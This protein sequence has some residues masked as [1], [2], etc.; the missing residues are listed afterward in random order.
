MTEGKG[1]AGDLAAAEAPLT[2]LRHRAERAAAEPNIV[3]AGALISAYAAAV[4][5]HI[6]SSAPGPEHPDADLS[7]PL[8]SLLTVIGA[9][10]AASDDPAIMIVDE[11]DPLGL[12]VLSWARAPLA[13]IAPWQ[14]AEAAGRTLVLARRVTSLSP[15]PTP[16]AVDL[17]VAC[18]LG[19]G[20]MRCVVSRGDQTWVWSVSTASA[21]LWTAVASADLEHVRRVVAES[22]DGASPHAAAQLAAWG[23][24]CRRGRAPAVD[25]GAI[26]ADARDDAPAGPLDADTA[27]SDIATAHR[28]AASLGHNAAQLDQLGALYAGALATLQRQAEHDIVEDQLLLSRRRSVVSNDVANSELALDAAFAAAA[29]RRSAMTFLGDHCEALIRG[30]CL[31]GIAAR[32]LRT[33]EEQDNRSAGWV[34][35]VTESRHRWDVA[36][37]ALGSLSSSAETVAMTLDSALSAIARC[38]VTHLDSVLGEQAVAIL[39]SLVL[40]PKLLRAADDFERSMMTPSLL[41]RE[42][43]AGEDAIDAVRTKAERLLDVLGNVLTNERG[44]DRVREVTELALRAPSSELQATAG[45]VSGRGA[46][47]ASCRELLR[48]RQAEASRAEYLADRGDPAWRAHWRNKLP[49][50]RAKV[51]AAR[52]RSRAADLSLAAALAQADRVGGPLLLVRALDAIGHGWQMLA[53]TPFPRHPAPPAVDL[54]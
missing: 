33:V 41:S 48:D 44:W 47:A 35:R 46:W 2:A 28:L 23:I 38:E 37:E 49:E 5:P 12:M 27:T 11:S 17:A 54:M 25:V 24:V 40:L 22:L 8:R 29:Q 39:D 21:A 34:D 14:Q 42:L 36:I 52:D 53:A 43:Y 16:S 15:L 4:G 1:S 7:S 6:G 30:G 50:W 13:S 18:R 19:V 26:E 32:A 10:A 45:L 20:S 51:V 31:S 3:E 9:V